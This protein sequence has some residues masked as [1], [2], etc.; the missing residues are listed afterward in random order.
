MPLTATS[1]AILGQLATRPVTTYELVRRMRR[2]L[3][4]FWPRAESRIYDEA[5]RLV[6]AKLATA[7]KTYRGKRAGTTYAITPEGQRALADWLSAPAPRWY[8]LEMEG[9]LR[10]TYGYL[11]TRE[12]LIR[13]LEGMRQEAQEM[14]RIGKA[15]GD[16]YLAGEA[17]F[18]P[19]VHIRALVFDLLAELGLDL[20][21][22]AE[23]SIAEVE[24]WDDLSPDGM[25]ERALDVIAR[26][27]RRYPV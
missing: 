1:Y 7:E 22:W 17:E 25:V 27:V 13:A 2:T 23:R 9:L 4:Y 20:I 19:Y 18:Q 6:A 26:Q 8:S 21:E 14:I 16:E 24:R 11:G 12:D 15:I 10:L 3:H 5:K